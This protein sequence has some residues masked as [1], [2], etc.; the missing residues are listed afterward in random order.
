MQKTCKLEIHI[1]KSENRN[2]CNRWTTFSLLIFLFIILGTQISSSTRREEKWK[3]KFHGSQHTNKGRSCES[4]LID[5]D[6]V[7]ECYKIRHL[8]CSN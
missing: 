2:F 5:R 8:I 3:S 1:C 6:H 4:D 7:P